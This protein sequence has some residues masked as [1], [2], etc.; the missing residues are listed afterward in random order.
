MIIAGELA[1]ALGACLLF[2]IIFVH[3]MSVWAAQGSGEPPFPWSWVLVAA[4][5]ALALAAIG[6]VGFALIGG[7]SRLRAIALGLVVVG[8][9]VVLAWVVFPMLVVVNRVL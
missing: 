8:C 7:R 2:A 9:A 6:S 1:V 4:A 5:A 3:G